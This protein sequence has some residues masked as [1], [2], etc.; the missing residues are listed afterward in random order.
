M[1]KELEDLM[2]YMIG[3]LPRVQSVFQETHDDQPYRFTENTV[4]ELID[5]YNHYYAL[6]IKYIEVKEK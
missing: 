6:D 1:N 2:M 3:G 5:L 4:N